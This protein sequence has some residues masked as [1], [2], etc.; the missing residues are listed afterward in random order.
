MFVLEDDAELIVGRVTSTGFE[1]TRRYDVGDIATWAQPTLSGN[2]VFVKEV[3]TL[4][5]WTFD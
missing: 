4:T 2:R 3:T 5:L 1:E